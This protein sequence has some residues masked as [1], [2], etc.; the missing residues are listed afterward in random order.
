LFSSP[1]I[2]NRPTSSSTGP[3]T[4]NPHS[5]V[6]AGES[7]TRDVCHSCLWPPGGATGS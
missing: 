2:I 5:P 1:D 3:Q 7:S 4:R 6:H